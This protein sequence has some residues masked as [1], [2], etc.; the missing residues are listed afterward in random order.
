VEEGLQVEEGH[1]PWV[2]WWVPDRIIRAQPHK[3]A[4]QQVVVELLR[5]HRESAFCGIQLTE[6]GIESIDTEENREPLRSC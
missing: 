6:G 5:R 4:D 3:P 2:A 1:S